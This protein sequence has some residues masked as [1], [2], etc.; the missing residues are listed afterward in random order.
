MCVCVCVCVCVV[1]HTRR[2]WKVKVAKMHELLHTC[3]QMNPRCQLSHSHEVNGTTSTAHAIRS[4]AL[5]RTDVHRPRS[6][7]HT[8]RCSALD[9]SSHTVSAECTRQAAAAARSQRAG[10]E[11]ASRCAT[12]HSSA[13]QRTQGREG[14]RMRDT[15]RSSEAELA[16]MKHAHTEAGHTTAQRPAAIALF[17]HPRYLAK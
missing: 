8:G 6:S 11:M 9:A 12:C 1:E 16:T 15:H 2:R 10:P 7:L 17:V 13:S 4:L 5:L 3:A 14:W